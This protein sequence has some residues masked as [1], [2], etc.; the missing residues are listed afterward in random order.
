M[1]AG[2]P[3]SPSIMALTSEDFPVPFGPIIIF[4]VG[5]GVNSIFVYDL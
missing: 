2:F 4:N 3:P 5:P 1:S